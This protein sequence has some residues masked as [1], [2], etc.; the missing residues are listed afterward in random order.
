MA[1]AKKGITI[2]GIEVSNFRRLKVAVVKMIPRI[3]LVRVTGRNKSGKTSLLR[4]IAAALG[5]AKEVNPSSV[6]SGSEGGG[7][8]LELSN[9][10][11][12]GRRVT[13][14][15]PKGYLTVIGADGGEHKQGKLDE[16]LGPLSFD[17]LAFFSLE[18]QRQAEILLSLGPDRELPS[19]LADIRARRAKRFD[20]RTPWISTKRRVSQVPKPDGERPR[21]VDVSAEMRRMGELQKAERE[22]DDAGRRE[23]RLRTEVPKLRGALEKAQAHVLD[24]VTQ[25]AAAEADV[26]GMEGSIQ[27]ATAA[28]DA[29]AID[30]LDLL[31]PA[32]ELA[33]VRARIE[34]ASAID[35]SIEPW[36][37]W[38]RAQA[39]LEEATSQYDR[40][41]AE[42]HA[43]DSEERALVA[44][45]PV[46]VEGLGFSP[47]GEPLLNGLPLEIA[48]GAE[49][50]ELA[51]GV[52][53]EVNPDLRVA[54]IDEANDLD[55]EAMERLDQRA[56]ERGF[57]IWACR[58]GIEG[59]GDVVVDDGEA[60]DRAEPGP[61]EMTGESL[62]VMGQ[63]TA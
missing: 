49:R 25:L 5:G 54:L 3:G 4:S 6:H 22:R 41:T 38:D 28:A 47:T 53:F 32:A 56:K 7:V 9:A 26:E 42:L 59:P 63:K 10:F 35:A 1:N 12:V 62:E 48:S 29:A 18:G 57:Q 55:L 30:F 37:A 14:A 17:P 51:V 16:W 24:L 11:S 52:A 50:I 13:P 2:V 15:N 58:L 33:Q 34:A 60:F 8:K 21:P 40:I 44:T 23:Q 19:K 27:S 46:P 36:K 43:F 39:E 20:E 61:V 45:V 31:D